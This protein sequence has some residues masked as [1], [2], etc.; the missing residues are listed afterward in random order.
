MAVKHFKNFSLGFGILSASAVSLSFLSAVPSN[1]QTPADQ[2]TFPAPSDSML[3][4]EPEPTLTPAPGSTM[5]GAKTETTDQLERQRDRCQG[6]ITA[7]NPY[8]SYLYITRYNCFP[9]NRLK[10]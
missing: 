9:A 2:P 5:E 7:L 1:A 3:N 6:R 8:T 4:S 10:T